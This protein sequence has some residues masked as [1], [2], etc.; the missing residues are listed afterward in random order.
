[1]C[2]WEFV[3]A[4][5][6]PSHTGR[7]CVPSTKTHSAAFEGA[8]V[9]T[10]LHTFRPFFEISEPDKWLG[11]KETFPGLYP[12]LNASSRDIRDKQLLSERPT[13]HKYGRVPTCGARS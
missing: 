10:V 6:S 9:E 2:V 5:L 7:L 13:T 8:A 12:V 1:M 11:V 4:R 3:R